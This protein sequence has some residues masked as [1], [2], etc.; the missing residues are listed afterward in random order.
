[1]ATRSDE[2]I[3]L[4][5]YPFRERDLVVTLLTR[6]GGQVRALARHVRGARSSRAAALDPLA[7]VRVSYFERPHSELATL[8]ESSVVRGSFG[9]A[10]SPAAWAAGQVI[11]ELT[12]AFCPPGERAEEP[13][14]LVDRTIAG[15]LAGIAPLVAVNYAQLWFLKLSGVLPEL[16]RCG[17]CGAALAPGAR[18]FD[19]REGSFVCALHPAPRPAE[20]ISAEGEA[21]LRAA[22]RTALE[23][24]PEPREDVASWLLGLT[25]HLAGKEIVS[26]RYLRLLGER[27]GP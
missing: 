26:W 9:L 7:L 8:D 17:V 13:F 25:Q 10:S 3:V 6:K 11:A 22:L 4:A 1:M 19:P 23:A 24:T 27:R 15:L 12:L 18:T 21:W 2:A 20:R 5:R 14:R 16:D